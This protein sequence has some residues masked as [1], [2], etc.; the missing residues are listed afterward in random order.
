MTTT[1][2]ITPTGF[3]VV[4]GPTPAIRSNVDVFDIDGTIVRVE[5]QHLDTVPAA[6]ASLDSATDLAWQESTG[7]VDLGFLN[8]ASNNLALQQAAEE[9]AQSVVT[10]EQGPRVLRIE[11]A[12]EVDSFRWPQIVDQL[13]SQHAT[14]IDDMSQAILA[15]LQPTRCRIGLCSTH[16]R[17]GKSTIAICLARWAALTGRRTLLIDADVENPQLT[18][19]S[20]LR[21]NIS[22]R[23][24]IQ[25]DLPLSEIL[26]RSA[27][28]G[29][30]VMP[31]R[32]GHR[33]PIHEKALN[34]L[35]DMVFQLKYE[36]DV[37]II[38]LGTVENICA[39]GT[40]GMDLVDTMLV[41][42]DQSRTS[43]GQALESRQVL[44]NLGMNQTSIAEN[45]AR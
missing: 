1:N 3:E 30:V 24:A 36:F 23:Q 37:V 26:V 14:L 33:P 6:H 12:W 31:A 21:P 18:V 45:F 5:S 15:N 43:N 41:I 32:P 44:K 28:T 4:T 17:E 19:K 22:W 9:L 25:L 29:L 7:S 39:H 8:V 27:E 11:P 35:C 40:E 10:T 2:H 42:R 20:G 34:E 13:L 38:D 16:P